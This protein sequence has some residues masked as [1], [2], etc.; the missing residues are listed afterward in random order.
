MFATTPAYT[1]VIKSGTGTPTI[2]VAEYGDN[3]GTGFSGDIGK[4][5]DVHIND[6]TD[7]DEIEIR[8]YYTDDEIEGLNEASLRLY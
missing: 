4:Y 5:I 3:P 8:L 6:I 7:V 2:T 1:E